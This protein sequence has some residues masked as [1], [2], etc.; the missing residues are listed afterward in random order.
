MKTYKSFFLFVLLPVLFFFFVLNI[1]VGAIR[2]PIKSVLMILT[3]DETVKE[4]WRYIVLNYRLPKAITAVM[5]GISLSVSGLLMQTLFRNPMADPYVLGLSSGSS[6]AVAFVVLGTGFMPFFWQ[7]IFLSST[8]IVLASV[9]GSLTILL[10]VLLGVRR[11]QEST[12]LLIVGLMFGSF[13]M[14]LVGV[15]SYFSTA[16]QLKRFTFWAMGSLGNLDKSSILFFLLAVLIGIGLSLRSVKALDAL[17]LGER[18]ARSMGVNIKTSR[19]FL[20]LS[21]S[22]LT[23]AA[24]AFTGPIAFVGLAVPHVARMLLKT[25]N[26]LSLILCSMIIGAVLMLICDTLTQFPGQAF[27]LPINAITSI[28]GAPIVIWLL[29]KK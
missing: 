18:Y 19:I 5:V 27:V 24:T 23:G 16:E 2:I 6:L 14:A 26:H 20:I 17:L 1:S 3:G 13:A 28:F 29:L 22:I 11:V 7:D 25:N 21:A 8:G 12:T 15:L 9:L 10:L 4:S